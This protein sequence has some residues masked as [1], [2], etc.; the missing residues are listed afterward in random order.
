[1]KP[2]HFGPPEQR[3]Q[4][5]VESRMDGDLQ[6]V[7]PTSEMPLD[8]GIRR[9][10]LILRA[11]GIETF[12]SCQGGSGHCFPEPTIRFH[13]NNWE[14]FKALAIAKSHGLPVAAVRLAWD[15]QDEIPHGPWWEMTFRTTDRQTA[16]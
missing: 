14:G 5:L 10:V 12:E 15:I 6:S 8:P 13:G 11:A 16:D 7:A 2:G 3:L 1:M 9:Y 4:V